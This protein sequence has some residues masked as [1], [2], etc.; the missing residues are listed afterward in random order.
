MPPHLQV[1]FDQSVAQGD[2]AIVTS[3]Q[4]CRTYAPPQRRFCYRCWG[5]ACDVLEHDIDTGDAEP[6]RQPPR[7]PPLSA[8]Q[9]EEDILKE[10]LQV[11][12]IKPSNS[13]WSSPVCMV[14]KKDGTYRVQI[15]RGL[16][17]NECSNHQRCLP[18]PDVKDALDSL[19]GA[20]F[21]KYRFTKP[22]WLHNPPPC[23][24]SLRL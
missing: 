23:A 15:L 19:R 1:L 16:P 24:L 5:F 8:R 10:M 7:R 18:V 12:V 2:L 11:G 4:P 17:P 14:R 21:A 9:A 13:R 22:Q 6:I 20:N 3:T